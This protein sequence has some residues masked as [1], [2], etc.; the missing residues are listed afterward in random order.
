VTPIQAKAREPARA[1][2][3]ERLERWEEA[4]RLKATV[5]GPRRER[6]PSR[7]S[8][9]RQGLGSL[10]LNQFLHGSSAQTQLSRYLPDRF[11]LFPE[12]V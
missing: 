6:L 12:T 8:D 7:R 11:A 1:E 9:G 4:E 2:Y 3:I 10:L 5:A